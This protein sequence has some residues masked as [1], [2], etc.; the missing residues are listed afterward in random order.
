MTKEHMLKVY[1]ETFIKNPRVAVF[2]I[3]AEKFKDLAKQTDL[4]DKS[5]KGE[6]MRGKDKMTTMILNS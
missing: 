2:R 6:V 1:E 5:L 3:F 4:E